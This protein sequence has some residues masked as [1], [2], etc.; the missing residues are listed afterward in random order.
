MLSALLVSACG[1]RVAGEG[2]SPADDSGPTP[3]VDAA[4]P[5]Q[6]PDAPAPP[7]SCEPS[8]H[9]TRCPTGYYEVDFEDA[10]GGERSC[11]CLPLSKDDC[12]Q[13]MRDGPMGYEAAACGVLPTKLCVWDP[14]YGIV[15]KVICGP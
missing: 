12:M 10:D 2:T 6:T 13:E 14:Y 3:V 8:S 5:S 4:A 7:L 11:E 9:V 15:S 1:G